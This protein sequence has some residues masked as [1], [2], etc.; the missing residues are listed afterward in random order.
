MAAP[1]PGTRSKARRRRCRVG[2]RVALAAAAA[3]GLCALALT[4]A[5]QPVLPALAAVAAVALFPRL[6]WLVVAATT[7]AAVSV[8]RPGAALLAGL[9]LLPV[10][11]LLRRTAPPGACPPPRRC[12]GGHARRRL[13]RP[14][15]PRARL[16]R[17][18]RARRARRLVGAARRVAAAARPARRTPGRT[19]ETVDQAA[20][21]VL[22]P[23]LE[24][25]VLLYAAIFAVAAAILPW[26]VRGRWF[27][28]DLIGASTWAAALGASTIAV[29]DAIG[30]PE[31]RNVVLASVVAGALAV[32]IPHVRRARVLEPTPRRIL[33]TGNHGHPPRSGA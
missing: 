32:A 11:L 27:A 7:L 24:S 5:E 33:C 14:G 17:P 6:G 15:R 9:A 23:L 13:P 4:W 16:V 21:Q 10:P 29:A 20:D 18:C 26:I 19:P 28:F 25:G 30:A 12:S 3:G 1:S 22:A 8:E 2:W 31:P